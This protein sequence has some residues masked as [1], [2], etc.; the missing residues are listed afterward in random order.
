MRLAIIVGHNHKE[1]GAK[2]HS[3]GYEYDFNS[4]LAVDLWREANE[5]GLYA[6]VLKKDLSP[7]RLFYAAI[8]DD[9]DCSIELHFNSFSDPNVQGSLVLY[10]ENKDFAERIQK[11]TL[12]ALTEDIN[13][14]RKDRGVIKP[15]K[16]SGYER[17]IVNMKYLTIP[18]CVVEPFFGSSKKD[19]ELFMRNKLRYCRAI[20]E[21]VLEWQREKNL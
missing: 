5:V 18:C 9:F 8:S 4:A 20:I 14:K 15:E 1:K 19:C 11:H 12:K 17:G 3:L 16:D 7:E 2:S 13:K 10:Y 6:R 21:A